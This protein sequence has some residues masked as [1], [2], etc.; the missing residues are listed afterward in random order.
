MEDGTRTWINLP[1]LISK[2]GKI[3]TNP[4]LLFK[5]LSKDPKRVWLL[6][7][8]ALSSSWR[9]LPREYPILGAFFRACDRLAAGVEMDNPGSYDAAI[10]ENF[11]NPNKPVWSAPLEVKIDVHA[12]YEM[13]VSRY[14]G[15]VEG[16]VE[17]DHLIENIPSV[18][19]RIDHPLLEDLVRVDYM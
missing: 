7:A 3:T 2:V 19:W 11:R 8:K 14:G 16:W 15:T 13:I 12:V 6:L 9:H 18:P 17:V 5:N 10:T 4:M 1:S